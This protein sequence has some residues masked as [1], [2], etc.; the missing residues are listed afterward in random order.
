MEHTP[1]SIPVSQESVDKAVAT[2]K[3][4]GIDSYVAKD[5]ADAWAK[6]RELI[7][8]GAQVMTMTSVTLDTLGIA[9]Q[10]NESGEYDSVR[11]KLGDPAVSPREKKMLGAAPEYAVG[12]VHAVTEDGKVIIASMTGSQL[13]A[14]VFGA[15]KVIWV[16]G[17]QK[18]TKDIQDAQKRLETHVLPL[19]SV[20]ANKAYN[21]TTGSYISKELIVNR[22]IVPGR[23]T[24]IFV[25]EVLGF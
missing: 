23:I 11:A 8:K 4:N 22:E 3:T 1:Y 2:L 24:V 19:E 9:K 16:V 12:S 7:P 13:P 14:Y 17:T 5:G 6:V 18:I 21:I 15:D 20:R 25:P 10:L